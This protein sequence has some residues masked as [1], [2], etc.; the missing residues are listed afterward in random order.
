MSEHHSRKSMRGRPL[1]DAE[2]KRA[3]LVGAALRVIQHRGFEGASMRRIAVEAGCTTGVL[4]HYFANKEDLIEHLIQDM[5]STIDAWQTEITANGDAYLAL[6]RI[7]EAP[8]AAGEHSEAWSLWY[9]LLLKARQD[10]ALAKRINV[11]ARQL[12]RALERLVKEDQGRGRIRNDQTADLL[13]E[14]VV[15]VAEGWSLMAPV[16]PERFRTER[17]H[18]LVH[19]VLEGLRPVAESGLGR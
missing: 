2:E 13:V 17:C 9:Q 10:A 1:A 3:T 6:Q 11:R 18:R 4:T 12:N 19:S 16:D 5:F 14:M 8:M 7:L 15:S